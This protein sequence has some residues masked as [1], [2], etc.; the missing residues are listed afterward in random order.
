MLSAMTTVV[1]IV[2]VCF[3][4]KLWGVGSLN[5]VFALG[6]DVPVMPLGQPSLGQGAVVPPSNSLRPL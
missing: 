6:C 3:D 1:S 5:W 4:G 2:A